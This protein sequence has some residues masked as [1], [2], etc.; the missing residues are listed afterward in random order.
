MTYF[1]NWLTICFPWLVYTLIWYFVYASCSR[2]PISWL[3]V[4]EFGLL[5][6]G[7]Q[8]SWFQ[9]TLIFILTVFSVWDCIIEWW[10]ES[11][12]KDI[13]WQ[14]G[15]EHRWSPW[16]EAKLWSWS[17][18]STETALGPACRLVNL[19]IYFWKQDNILTFS[20]ISQHWDDADTNDY[21][22]EIE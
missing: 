14:W 12:L 22:R 13:P 3:S 1:S 17:Q 18:H 9:I 4:F 6:C 19:W 8:Q 10:R 7:Q 5:A 2:T 20:N 16:K 21:N 11:C 15:C